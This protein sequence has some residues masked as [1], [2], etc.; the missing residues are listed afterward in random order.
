MPPAWAKVGGV[1]A[2]FRIWV[3]LLLLSSD[4]R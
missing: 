1:V 2:L 3:P 4:L